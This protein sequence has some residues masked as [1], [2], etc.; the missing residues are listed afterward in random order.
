MKY[1]LPFIA[2]LTL[3]LL[4]AAGHA[5]TF[6]VMEGSDE[7]LHVNY[8]SHLR[9]T[10][11]LPD[12]ATRATNSTQQA[13]GQP[14][15]AYAIYALAADALT[16][17]HVDADA[18]RTHVEVTVRNRWFQPHDIWARGDNQNVY[19]HGHAEAAFDHPD[20]VALVRGLRLVS[21]IWLLIGVAGAYAAARVVFPD[22]RWALTATALY[23]LMPTL[24]HT[25]GYVTNDAPAIALCAWATWAGLRLVRPAERGN[26]GGAVLAGLILAA[27][28]WMKVN[29]LVIAPAIGLAALIGGWRANSPVGGSNLRQ[30]VQWIGIAV[31]PALIFSTTLLASTAPFFLYGAITY[32]DPFGLATHRHLTP[33]FYFDPPRDLI[34]LLPDLPRLYL[35]YWG[36]FST[37]VHLHPATYSA[38][39][40]VVAVSVAGWI[41]RWRP[42]SAPLLAGKTMPVVI[43]RATLLVL[44][45]IAAVALAAMIRWMQQLAF[46]GGRLMYPA[47]AAI[48]LLVTY[49]AYRLAAH[50]PA[51]ARGILRAAIIAPLA[52]AALIY[53]PLTLIAAYTP[54]PLITPPAVTGTTPSIGLFSAPDGGAIRLD[55]VSLPARLPPGR[56]PVRL[57]WTVT[58]PTTRPAAFTL[59]LIRDG[60]IVADRTSVFGMGRFN[61]TLW[62]AGDAFCDAFWLPY[63]DPDQPADPDPQPA[64]RY[65]I[66]IGVLDAVTLAADW[67]PDAPGGTLIAGSVVVPAG[68]MT[69][70]SG[71][72]PP[73]HDFS[74]L[75]RLESYRLTGDP[76][77]G[78]TLTLELV[79]AVT[80]STP[81][82]WAQFIHLYGDD[83][84]FVGLA[85]GDP[86]GGDYPTTAWQ[87]GERLTD[88]WTV[89]LPANLPAAS[90][91]IGIG[92]YRRD[93]G[94]RLPVT[95]DG[96]PAPD[97]I[98]HLPLTQN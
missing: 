20:A 63:D 87:P 44:A 60:V 5:L 11:T 21:I 40:I 83:G 29:A 64:Q 59:K 48:M 56:A 52:A 25:G 10:G 97:G 55:S 49:G 62:Q 85:D 31:L 30:R 86:R 57:C 6:P 42:W 18:L 15:L 71:N 66:V 17:P 39:G 70:H 74:G 80:G 79:W 47:H 84:S 90:Y 76:R 75:A 89:T 34:A 53:T 12:R 61:S 9:E 92:F 14:P 23:A 38:F 94:G 24:I 93:T 7:I 73:P 54:P 45:I 32:G 19:Y 65:Q 41:M 69:W 81:D 1:R 58:T 46:T 88:T 67:T 98:L 50:W 2:L 82:A 95:V 13:S 8:V 36:V 96:L 4:A 91:R 16:L 33:G 51:R 37:V 43:D 72:T 68:V 35:S 22:P 3:V 78:A 27:A 77:P 26:I 28:A